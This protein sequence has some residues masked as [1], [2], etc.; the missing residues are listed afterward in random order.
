MYCSSLAVL[1]CFPLCA[2]ESLIDAAPTHPKK[3][4]KETLGEKVRR[5]ALEQRQI[6]EERVGLHV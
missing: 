3:K 6:E 2:Y 1:I 5:M 4:K